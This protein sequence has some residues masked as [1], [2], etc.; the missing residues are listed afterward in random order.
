MFG[1]RDPPLGGPF[2]SP[3]VLIRGAAAEEV[4]MND[5]NARYKVVVENAEVWSLPFFLTALIIAFG[6]LWYLNSDWRASGRSPQVAVVY[7][8]DTPESSVVPTERPARQR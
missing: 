3:I 6:F 2:L 1:R 4:A 5:H 7:S 8:T